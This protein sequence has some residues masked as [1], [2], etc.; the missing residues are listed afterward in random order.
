MFIEQGIPFRNPFYNYLVGIIM[1]FM[2]TLVGQLPM[3]LAVYWSSQHEGRIYPQSQEAIMSFFDQNTTLFFLLLPFVFAFVV[4]LFVIKVWHKQ[5]LLTVITSRSTLDWGRVWFS[6]GL[7]AIISIGFVLLEW[8]F[9]PTHFVWNFQLI[10]FLVLCLLGVLFIPIQTSTEELLF[11]GYLLQGIATLTPYRW[12]PLLC[13]SI[14]FGLLHLANPEVTKMGYGLLVYYIGTG[15]FLGV[16]TMMDDGMELALGFHAANNLIG[17]LLVTSHWTVFQ[18]HSLLKD[19]SEPSF[20]IDVFLPV[21]LLYPIL[22]SIF[23]KRYQWNRWKEKL[24]GK[25]TNF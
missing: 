3:L 1:V 13:T 2:A 12:L 10:P 20:G 23:V 17:A 21:L 18:T 25:I 6:F 22:L 4:L 15:L 9:Y 16:I 5:P 24:F 8:Y 14:V 11:R 19:V 7:W